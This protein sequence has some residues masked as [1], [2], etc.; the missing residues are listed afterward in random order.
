[1][2]TAVFSLNFNS[3]P[4]DVIAQSL[5]LNKYLVL[6]LTLPLLEGCTLVYVWNAA[7]YAL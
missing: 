2:S 4:N 7:S 3:V 5:T 1:M 6:N